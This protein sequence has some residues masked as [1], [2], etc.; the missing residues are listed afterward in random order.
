MLCVF[1]FYYHLAKTL[2]S[3]DNKVLEGEEEGLERILKFN[4]IWVPA[5]PPPPPL[6]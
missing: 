2:Y 5:M 6:K 1:Y 4:N 3:A